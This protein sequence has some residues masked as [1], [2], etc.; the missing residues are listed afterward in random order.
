MIIIIIMQ[1]VIQLITK[2]ME[3]CKV[4]LAAGGET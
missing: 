3:N 2:A 4:E 1:E